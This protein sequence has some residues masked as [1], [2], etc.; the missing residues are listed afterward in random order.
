MKIHVFVDRSSV[1]VFGN[2]GDVVITDQI[3]PSFQSQG[4]EVYAKGGD[5][6]LVSLDVWTLNSILGK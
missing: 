3:F 4:L 2:D 6:R 1:E 5:A